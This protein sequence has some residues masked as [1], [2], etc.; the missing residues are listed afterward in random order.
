MKFCK[1]TLKRT[2]IV[3]CFCFVVPLLSLGQNEEDLAKKL[4]NPV[5]SLISVPIQ[6]N[7]DEGYGPNGDGSVWKT[8]IQ[9]VIPIELNGDWNII[10]RT[11]LPIVDQQDIPGEGMGESGLGDTVQSIFFSPKE[12]TEGGWITGYGPVILLPTGTKEALSTE[13]WGLGP[14][15]VA[16]KQVGPTTYGLL[17]NHIWSVAGD[18]DRSEVSASLLQ[19]FAS[20]VTKTKTTFAVSSEAT[21]DWNAGEWSVP[22][23]V[24]VSQLLKLGNQILQVGIG[25]RYWLDSTP[26][27]P[28]GWGF[29]FQ[30]TLLYP[31]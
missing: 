11:I 20:Y 3:V 31:K 12:P 9:P 26:Y 8:N 18:D 27:G 29:R 25:A 6:L 16:L 14:T 4:A 5:A 28:E 7:Y 2:L 22:V 17:A 15:G 23:N 1:R 10:S 21:Y 19:P 30:V 24:N 13:K